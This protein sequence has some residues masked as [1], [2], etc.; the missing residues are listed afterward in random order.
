[1]A[2]PAV[3]GLAT[4][5]LTI[6]LVQGIMPQIIPLLSS[7][8]ADLPVLTVVVIAISRALLDHGLIGSIAV[9]LLA[10]AIMFAYRKSMRVRYVA[11]KVLLH[12]PIAGRLINDLSLTLFFRAFGTMVEAGILADVAYEKACSTVSFLPLKCLLEQNISPLKNGEKFHTIAGRMPAYVESLITAGEASGNLGGSLRR[13]D[14]ILGK[15][16]EH[17]LK[18]ITAMVE[19]A[20]MIGMGSM[21]GSIA[22]SIMMPI[23]DISKNLQH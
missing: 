14:S 18:K 9:V 19:P 20:M 2:Y 23:Y 8:H 17:A 5:A 13:I 12:I 4:V 3:I 6:G 21:V 16:L 1:M 10:M 22:L 7:L 11:Q 15:E